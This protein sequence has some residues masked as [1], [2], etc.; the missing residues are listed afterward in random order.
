MRTKALVCAAIL[1][2]G[3]ASS[4]AQSNVYSLNVVGYYNVTVPQS[5]YYLVANQLNTT[6][7]QIQYV[8]P[9]VPNDTTLYK[10]TGGGYAVAQWEDYNPGW[11]T[12]TIT[13]NPGETAFV[14]DVAGTPGG[15]TLTFVGE[16]LQGSLV[17]SFTP[18]T[19]CFRSSMVPQAASLAVLGIVGENDDTC[20]VYTGGGYA[21]SQFEDYNPGWD[22]DGSG[23]GPPI[24]VGQGFGFLKQGPTTA[25][26]RNFT[27]Q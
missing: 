18:G 21:V 14:R 9:T 19:V 26:V 8:L 1:A 23:N 12:P 10:Y 27:V 5:G 4:M 3:L 6:N 25:W 24:A 20:Y 2:A 15:L 11:D 22:Y 13:L 7:N 17:N 16:V